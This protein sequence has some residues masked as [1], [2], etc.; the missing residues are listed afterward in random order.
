MAR[1][2]APDRLQHVLDAAIAVF[3]QAGY[4]Q[5]RIEDVARAAG[6]AP[7]TVLLYARSKEALFELALRH[8]L[9]DHSVLDEPLPYSAPPA[10]DLIER[11]WQ[12]LKAVARFPTLDAAPKKAPAMGGRAELEAIIREGYRWQLHYHRALLLVERCARDWPELAALFYQEFRRGVLNRITSHLKRRAEQ[13][14][15]RELPDQAVA[16]RIVVEIIAFFAMHRHRAPD[17]EMDDERAEAA[18]VDFISHA[19]HPTKLR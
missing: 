15:L 9:H 17:S 2:R 11:V 13:G 3:I 12:R 6:V 8:A 4:R 18:V 7:A 16:A 1:T 5:G 10:T 19:L 14:A